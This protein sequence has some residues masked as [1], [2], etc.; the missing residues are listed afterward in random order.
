MADGEKHRHFLGAFETI[1]EAK[2]R[3]NCAVLGNASYAYVKD[4]SGCTVFHLT[5]PRLD[6]FEG[7]NYGNSIWRP[8]PAK[9]YSEVPTVICKATM[10]NGEEKACKSE[11]EF[12]ELVKAYLQ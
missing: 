8:D 1:R 10:P 3:A 6:A 2:H 4:T 7:K 9:K 12:R 5:P 11:G